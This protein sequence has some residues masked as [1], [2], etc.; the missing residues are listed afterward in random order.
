M[1]LR[2]LASAK[3]TSGAEP[4]WSCGCSGK[5]RA[6]LEDWARTVAEVTKDEA[7]VQ[8]VRDF[9]AGFPNAPEVSVPPPPR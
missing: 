9:A 5:E 2:V 3:L 8:K 7:L 1:R 6:T 4:V